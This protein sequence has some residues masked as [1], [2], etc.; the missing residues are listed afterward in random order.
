MEMFFHKG[1]ELFAM[2]GE[3]PAQQEDKEVMEH[4][5]IETIHQEG[6]Q[7]TVIRQ[8]VDIKVEA[9]AEA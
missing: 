5:V 9:G 7:H 1:H 4:P 2:Y 8:A 6:F 3:I